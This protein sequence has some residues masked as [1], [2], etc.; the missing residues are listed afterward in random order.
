MK[1]RRFEKL[2]VN[3]SRHSARVAERAEQLVRLTNPQPGQRLLDVGCGNGA[4]AVHLASVFAL[5]VTGIDVDPEQVD[6]ALA[7]GSGSA[8][9]RFVVADALDLPFSDGEFDLVHTNKTTHHIPDWR[10]ALAEMTRVLKPAGFLVYT[11]FVA[12][13]G[14]RLPTR[15]ALGRFAVEQHLETTYRAGSL[16]RAT[17]I[18]RKPAGG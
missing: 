8:A 3:R 4:A 12:P 2:L 17:A 15:R 14:D 16:V 5:D 1:M 6:A 10:Q 9:V 18:F 11:D 13:L 7:A